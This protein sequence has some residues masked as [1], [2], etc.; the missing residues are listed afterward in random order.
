MMILSILL[1]CAGFGFSQPQTCTPKN[2]RKLMFLGKSAPL[3]QKTPLIEKHP[4]EEGFIKLNP[5]IYQP[6]QQLPSQAALQKKMGENAPIVVDQDF[7]GLPSDGS[8]NPD[9]EGDVGPDHYF[10]MVKSQFA[11]WDKT[12]NMLYG[13]ADCKTLWNDF[14]GPWL[15]MG[16]TDPVVL[17]D[18]LADRWLASCMVY[19][20]NVEYY[21][22]VAV[23][24]TPDP[25]GEWYCYDIWFDVMPDYP[26]FGLW[27]DAY[28]L[29]INEWEINGSYGTFTGASVMALN[30]EQM[31]AGEPDP[32][33]VYFHFDAPNH[34]T[35][36]DVG[37]F[38]PS[39]LDGPP[40]P[41]GTP[42]IFVC[43]KD[44]TWGYPEDRLWLWSFSIDWDDMSN[45]SFTELAI[46]PTA[47]FDSHNWDQDFIH[48][49]NSTIK[50]HSLS[51]FLMYRLQYRYH[52]DHQ[53]LVCNHT[54]ETDGAEHG[55]VRWYA[56]R[57]D[58]ADWLI[59][60]QSTYVPNEESRWMGSVA[61]DRDGNLAVGYSV[62]GDATYPSIR[63]AGRRYNDPPG[64][65]TIPETE[66][67]T[68]S[69]SQ[70][71]HGRWGD[72]ST[73]SVDPTDDLTFW[74][75]QEYMETSGP[76]NWQTRIV[77]F[78]LHKNPDFSADSLIFQTAIQ[79]AEGLP[80]VLTNP[81]GYDMEITD[82]KNEGLVGTVPWFLEP[83][84]SLPL[85]LSPGASLDLLVKVDLATGD[86]P[87]GFVYDTLAITTY[88]KHYAITIGLNEDLI[89][90][91]QP[92][93]MNNDPVTIVPNPFFD[94]TTFAITVNEKSPV[95]VWIF[96]SQFTCM[97]TLGSDEPVDA[98]VVRLTWDGK[99]E[100][101]RTV[102]AGIYYVIIRIGGQAYLQKI[103]KT[104]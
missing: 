48:Q 63:A 86:L 76:V 43:V 54:V 5:A 24:A 27:P 16:W 35:T 23:S 82:I 36:A 98:G 60:Q 1:L 91:S 87:A 47:P 22:M 34:S 49:P 13:P 6:P 81:T 10:Q 15:D 53:T 64:Q 58:G 9:T 21:E 7:E 4:F 61:M 100:T 69:A 80:L 28:Y 11:I 95:Q 65:L 104:R 73:L 37:S 18:H 40:P 52:D 90:A 74:Y 70:T 77:S 46:L 45:C 97:R 33:M 56:L 66:I 3:N 89:S 93:T 102:S 83:T 96:N 71:N 38:L 44:D 68:G 39:D 62:S 67:K 32:D 8:P 51:H 19:E 50:L 99:S 14:P 103:I 55:A 88:Y 59:D 12:G 30:R 31:L 29:S 57:N 75:T 85:T 79:C 42:N 92:A 41:E 2:D 26:K 84:V 101:G 25:L 72:Y 94:Q 20:L 17:Y 78:R